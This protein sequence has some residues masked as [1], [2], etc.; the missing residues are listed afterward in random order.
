[1][2]RWCGTCRGS[3]VIRES[4]LIK[5]RRMA[6]WGHCKE[7][8]SQCSGGISREQRGDAPESGLEAALSM[9]CGR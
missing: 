3:V 4:G 7:S 1:M 6:S 8:A 5:G 9:T 2:D